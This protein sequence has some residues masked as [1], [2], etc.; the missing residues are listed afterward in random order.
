[1][2]GNQGIKHYEGQKVPLY[3]TESTRNSLSIQKTSFMLSEQ[4]QRTFENVPHLQWYRE[5]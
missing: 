2:R 5:I 3:T 1:M 4:T